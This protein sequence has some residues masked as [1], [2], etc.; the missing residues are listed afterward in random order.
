MTPEMCETPTCETELPSTERVKHV[1]EC[2]DL[3]ATPQPDEGEADQRERC[4]SNSELNAERPSGG[5][6]LY[7]LF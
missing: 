4:W 7:R 6:K 1:W 3:V 2:R 5:S